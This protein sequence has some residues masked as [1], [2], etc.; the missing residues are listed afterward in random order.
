[1][2]RYALEWAKRQESTDPIAKL[3]LVLLADDAEGKYHKGTMSLRELAKLICSTEGIVE[4]GL[5]QLRAD[6]FAKYETFVGPGFAGKVGQTKLRYELLVP[7]RWST[8]FG[9]KRP[10]RT[11]EPTDE[12]TAVYRFYDADGVLLYVGIAND[13]EGRFVQHS[14]VQRW[15]IDVCTREVTWYDD[16]RTAEVEEDRAILVEAPKYNVRGVEWSARNNGPSRA[17]YI[18]KNGRYERAHHLAAQIINDIQAGAFD[19]GPIPEAE[20]LAERYGA[21]VGLA[22][23]AAQILI[24]GGYIHLGFNRLHLGS[25]VWAW[26]R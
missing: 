13:P 16:R 8:S 4:S 6:G 9:G 5:E 21:D 22:G 2:S 25:G 3:A 17:R 18:V 26:P 12:P 1:M 7:D 11:S 23:A 14:K 15:W 24:K 10:S 20:D 19:D